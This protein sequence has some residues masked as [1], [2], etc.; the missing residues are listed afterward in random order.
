M[1]NPN[2]GSQP[3]QTS[4][5]AIYSPF[6]YQQPAAQAAPHQ[7]NNQNY[8]N[9]GF[10]DNVNN[11]PKTSPSA[12][13]NH[14]PPQAA[15]QQTN[16]PTQTNYV[17]RFQ[18]VNHHENESRITQANYQ[19]PPPV[20]NFQRAQHP[21]MPSPSTSP[22][23][24]PPPPQ[25]ESIADEL[26][27][28]NQQQN[29]PAP[30]PVQ[31]YENN[32][33]R[34]VELAQRNS[35]DYQH[36]TWT[37]KP[38]SV[39]P[40]HASQAPPQSW[41]T[42]SNVNLHQPTLMQTA[43]VT[44]NASAFNSSAL[45]SFNS[46]Q[47][48]N[49]FHEPQT[50]RTQE[51]SFSYGTSANFFE[52][53]ETAHAVQSPLFETPSVVAAS[54][55]PNPPQQL[56]N[57]EQFVEH[58]TP[59]Q[60]T[61]YTPQNAEHFY[62]ENRERL[63]DISSP[64]SASFTDRHNYLVTGQLSQ[65]RPIAP[66]HHQQEDNRVLSESLPPPGLSRMVVGQPESNQQQVTVTDVPPPGLNRMVTGTE[67]TPSNYMNYQRQA[68]GEVSQ[69][70]SMAMPRPQ[71]NSPFTGNLHHHQ[72]IVQP[73]FNTSD[74]NLYLVAGESDV[75][76]QRVI[77]GVESNFS[78]PG[79]LMSPMQNLH[80]Q[81]H[82]E[83]VNV[84]VPVQERNVNVDGM[85]TVP[86]SQQLSIDAQPTR[87]EVIDGANDNTEFLIIPTA[88]H[89][90]VP[91]ALELESDV[92]VREEAIE[93][94]NDDAG[95]PIDDGKLKKL[96]PEIG[97]SSEDSELRELE[98]NKLK[99]KSHRSKKYDTNE[100]ENEYSDNDKKDRSYRRVPREKMSREEYEKNRRREKERRSGDR[101]RKGDDTDG[102][103]YGDS[104]RRTDDDE[105][106]YRKTREKFKKSVRR[107]QEGEEVD[108]KDRKK[109]EKYRE[110]GSRRSK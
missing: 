16:L 52:N 74:R 83:F 60:V 49:N 61:S 36:P 99:P 59:P 26:Y 6:G 89:A 63:D 21:F 101:P 9:S 13:F 25:A 47:N 76:S 42:A 79:N 96:K 19:Q 91:P 15:S 45:D 97:M 40:I 87:E 39:D 54:A 35:F 5:S 82:D 84:S 109:R 38:A 12:G 56:E 81:D 37:Q 92:N 80:I 108:D 68:D 62:P 17:D 24:L 65:E 64:P 67:T 46:H 66:Q 75:N 77:P 4:N 20:G 33:G 18:A 57:V 93:G 11:N 34:K 30:P 104:K 106:D 44:Q 32:F 100:S 55:S 7:F 1:H 86:E 14:L 94:A 22:L 28:S 27:T 107:Q 98:H 48:V 31:N 85:E 88:E 110:S 78:S 90:L 70:P 71:S 51:G 103:K 41:P 69:A 58:V 102:S 23:Q 72:D 2:F 95:K 105:D 29:L 73:S 53:I 43:P 3:P 10:N 8:Y 50:N